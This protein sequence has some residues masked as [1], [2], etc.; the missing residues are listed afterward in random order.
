MGS[1]KSYLELP[2]EMLADLGAYMSAK[3][4]NDWY[5][6]KLYRECP[7]EDCEFCR[8]GRVDQAPAS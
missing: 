5:R 3:R 7:V 2:E 1:D 8:R 4:M 6:H